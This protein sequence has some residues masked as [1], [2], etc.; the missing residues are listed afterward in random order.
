[1]MVAIVLILFISLGSS[2]A[3]EPWPNDVKLFQ[4]YEVEQILLPDNANCLAVQ[5]FLKMCQ[6]NHTLEMRGNA[7]HMS[8]SAQSS[9]EASIFVHLALY[10]KSAGSLLPI[11]L[12][13]IVLDLSVHH[14]TITL[15]HHHTTPPPPDHSTTTT[16]PH[17]FC[18]YCFYESEVYDGKEEEEEEEED[19]VKK[20]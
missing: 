1:M 19:N 15:L 6:L 5:A 3:Q 8:P 4:Q 9:H 10:F 14:L 20:R 17:Q 11:K 13:C 18:R 7:E 2:A 16:S 12:C